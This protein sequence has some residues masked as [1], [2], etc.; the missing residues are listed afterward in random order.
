MQNAS[1]KEHT[2]A[3]RALLNLLQGQ[4]ISGSAIVYLRDVINYGIGNECIVGK[5]DSQISSLSRTILSLSPVCPGSGRSHWFM[6]RALIPR[7][8]SIPETIYA[9]DDLA[10]PELCDQL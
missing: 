7:K 3:G 5:I 6:L 1:I 10:D 8:L 4:N 2:R 9:K